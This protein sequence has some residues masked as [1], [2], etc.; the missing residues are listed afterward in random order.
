MVL[1][2]CRPK[3]LTAFLRNSQID[4]AS[5][6]GREMYAPDLVSEILAF[7]KV[8]L[9]SGT[10]HTITRKIPVTTREIQEM[11]LVLCEE[12]RDYRVVFEKILSDAGV[13]PGPVLKFGSIEAINC[14]WCLRLS[15][16]NARPFRPG[17]PGGGA[18]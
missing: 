7:E 18:M 16:E 9:V 15:P 4:A 12:G 6:L 1:K 11:T 13:L 10:S 2:K 14:L 5:I 17:H 8:V 3:E